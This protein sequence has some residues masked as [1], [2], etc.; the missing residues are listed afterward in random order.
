M[1]R[2]TTE[3]IT[4]IL[5]S[6]ECRAVFEGS[7]DGIVIVDGEGRIRATNPEVEHLFGYRRRDLVGEPVE[8]LVPED[9]RG[10]H[11]RERASY[12][13]AP[14]RRPMGVEL[15]LRGRRKDGSLFPVEI[16]LSPIE[17][18]LGPLTVATVRDVT[19][20]QSL[21]ALGAAAI[22][23]AEEERERIARELHDDMA[24]RMAA[25]LVRLRLARNTERAERREELLEEMR[26]EILGCTDAV[27]R[28]AHGL[29]PPALEEVGLG[30]AIRGHVR[31]VTRDE[32]LDVDVEV[33]A[34]LGE[35]RFAPQ[36]ELAVY[37]IVQEA[38]A[39]VVR[40]ADAS[41]CTIA[42][43]V[44]A[45][46]LIALVEDDGQGFDMHG[47]ALLKGLGL[48]GMR[49]RVRNLGG[50]FTIESSPGRGTRIRAEIPLA[51]GAAP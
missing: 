51:D 21:R 42:L 41:R 12:V 7:P 19:E 30:S 25:L 27:R 33:P 1:S 34:G 16:S 10:V 22:R 48:V 2:E 26:D 29:R 36:I 38:L 13:E 9:Q 5:T 37:R 40:H 15:E 31:D 32:A 46:G 17:T 14:V 11:E 18:T 47:E 8:T 44:D 39:N 50:G 23:A 35:S 3:M 43:E 49:E 24:Q 20:R 6:E 4:E 28:I 45:D